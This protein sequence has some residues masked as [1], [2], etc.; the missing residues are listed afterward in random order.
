MDKTLIEA[1][2]NLIAPEEVLASFEVHKVLED[3]SSI[4]IVM[5]EKPELLPEALRDYPHPEIV[6]NGFCNGIELRTFTQKG[7][8]T[9]LQ[10]LRRRWKVKGSRE[11]YSNKYKFHEPEA[12]LTNPLAFYLKKNI[13]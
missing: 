11:S 6:L 2:L 7:K 8:A 4:T 5:Q 10:L 12:K 9:Y 3:K 13:R 1:L